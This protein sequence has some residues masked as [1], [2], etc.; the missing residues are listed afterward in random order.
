[1][2]RIV[3]RLGAVAMIALFIA[4]VAG[5]SAMAAD[6][7]VTAVSVSYSDLDLSKPG[8]L[9][10]LRSRVKA[11]AAQVCGGRPDSRDLAAM[12]RFDVCA[13]N[14]IDGAFARVTAL[15]AVARSPEQVASAQ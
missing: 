8:G 14:A 10:V 6:T 3:N 13:K 15:N 12:E 5:V 7:T 1:M 11:A 4:P 9:Q 2:N